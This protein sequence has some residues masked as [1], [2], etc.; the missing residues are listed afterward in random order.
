MP[1]S[2]GRSLSLI[3]SL[4]LLLVA[5]NALS[6]PPAQ[7]LR[8]TAP[9]ANVR[10]DAST[11][12]SVLFQAKRGDDLLLLDEVGD[13]YHVQ[14]T[15]GWQ[16][17][18]KKD[19]AERV[20][21]TVSAAATPTAPAAPAVPAPV[22]TPSTEGGPAIDH[23][24]LECILAESFPKLNASFAPQDV[25]KA[26][27]YFRAEGGIHWYYV[28]MTL[29]DGAYLG[30]L[31]KPKV[32]TKKIDYYVEAVGKTLVSSR[33]QE[34]LPVVVPRS[35]DCAS[36]LMA[37]IAPVAKL[38]V[39]STAAGAPA[40]PEGFEAAG[41]GLSSS[42]SAGAAAAGHT[43]TGT[44]AGS[45]SAASSSHTVL[46][47]AGGVVAAGGL[48]LAVKGGS[49]SSPAPTV[50]L[51]GTWVGP[52]TSTGSTS[53][54]GVNV[55]CTAHQTLTLHITQSGGGISGTGSGSGGTESCNTPG[56]LSIPLTTFQ[57]GSGS[58]TGTASNG[59]FSF[60]VS[61]SPLVFSGTYTS[62]TMNGSYHG[63][64][65]EQSITVDQSGSF[66]LT[67]Q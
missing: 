67:K 59:Q 35:A 58:F 16:G 22:P 55:T 40:I 4:G 42:A 14:S 26:R 39:G 41:I 43:S 2:F 7:H 53:A 10:S 49:S 3:A 38:F 31:P 47:V 66:T 13:W 11:R 6:A 1:R 8:V 45:T 50:D 24:P 17:Y 18:M 28:E 29:E 54:Q 46:Y 19:L 52:Y 63:T 34:Y 44:S 9:L 30:I 64:T 56:I 21:S 25:A 61:G 23:R 15:A 5:S 48:A 37:A 65:T 27:V 51:N 36:K 62:T 32:T 60:G 33:T 57:G 12:G 20:P